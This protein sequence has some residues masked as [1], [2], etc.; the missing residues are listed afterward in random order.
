MPTPALPYASSFRPRW[1]SWL[2]APPKQSTLQYNCTCTSNHSA[3]ALQYYMNSIVYFECQETLGLCLSTNAGDL[4]AQTNCKNT[5]IC[6]TANATLAAATSSSAPTSTT[7][8]SATA[9]TQKP[10]GTTTHATS[11]AGAAA[12]RLAEQYGS[13]ALAAGVLGIVGLVL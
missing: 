7:V 8:T 9:A 1:T 6:G 10:S 5:I 13:G 4:A 12:L 11:S 2:T 3:P